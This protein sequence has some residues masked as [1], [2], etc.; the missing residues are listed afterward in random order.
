LL[1]RF[2]SLLS[3][4]EDTPEE[5]R[6]PALPVSFGANTLERCIIRIPVSFEVKAQIKEWR[7]GDSNP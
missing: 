7:I 2:K 5:K 6:Q 1:R 3:R 4:V